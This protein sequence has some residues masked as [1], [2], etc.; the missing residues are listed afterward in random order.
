M[1]DCACVADSTL[2]VSFTTHKPPIPQMHDGSSGLESP[3]TVDVETKRSSFVV[4]VL[5]SIAALY[6]RSVSCFKERLSR[7]FALRIMFLC[8]TR[9]WSDTDTDIHLHK[10]NFGH[11]N[12]RPFCFCRN[13]FRSDPSDLDDYDVTNL[14]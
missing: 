10:G 9:R 3:S 1:I 5:F 2:K 12:R 14:L 6:L 7:L 13:W 4:Y 8:G 11:F